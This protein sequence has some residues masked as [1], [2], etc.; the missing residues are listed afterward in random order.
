MAYNALTLVD[1][2]LREFHS[3][4]MDWIMVYSHQL[5]VVF[6]LDASNQLVVSLPICSRVGH[7]WPLLPYRPDKANPIPTCTNGCPPTIMATLFALSL[8]PAQ[9]VQECAKLYVSKSWKAQLSE[10]AKEK[11]KSSPGQ[12]PSTSGSS[13][14]QTRH[15]PD[16]GSQVS[17]ADSQHT[18]EAV[19]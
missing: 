7:W 1:Q 6:R 10:R 17:E 8:L 12:H 15:D 13:L 19:L 16:F 4:D 9:T 3:N 18:S 2:L 14:Q 11:S 5:A